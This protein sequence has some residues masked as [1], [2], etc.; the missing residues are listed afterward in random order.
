MAQAVLETPF[1][2]D[3]EEGLEEGL[4]LAMGLDLGVRLRVRTLIYM[5]SSGR[6]SK[7]TKNLFSLLSPS[8][9]TTLYDIFS[10][11]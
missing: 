9:L 10:M 7:F 2:N 6:V 5:P 4:E 3:L 8:L 1:L 11:L